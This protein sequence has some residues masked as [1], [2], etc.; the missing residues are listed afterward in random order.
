[1]EQLNPSPK[2]RVRRNQEPGV[3]EV[4][5]AAGVSIA[6]V[7]RV[8]NQPQVVSAKTRERVQAA[9]KEL[10]F[11]LNP[12]ASALRRGHGNVI[13]V[14]A[15]SLAQPWYT[16]LM[17]ALKVEIEARGFTVMQVD[18]QHDPEVLR[19][20]LL[21]N[22]QH[23]P[24]GMVLATGDL[25]AD[26]EIIDAIQAAHSTRPVVVIGQHVPDAEW[27]TVQFTDEEWAYQATREMLKHSASVA[28][29]GTLE[30]SYL[31]S[32]RL[33]GYLRAAREAD[34]DE[35]RW[36]WPIEA[37]GYAA[38]FEAVRRRI[39][40][41]VVP[42]AILAINDELALGASRALLTGELRIP[43][44]V[45]VMGFGNTDFLEYV[46]PTLS[47]VD[48]SAVDAARVAIDALWAQFDEHEF[49]RLTVL[50]RT[51]VHRESTRHDTRP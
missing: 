47:S 41:G 7:S 51:I 14:L 50:E 42:G 38:G 30:G 33:A 21:P 34:L 20:A 49:P 16:K 37:R 2:T 32:E 28:F 26:A 3:T 24:T 18:L 4:A 13:T 5:Q 45:A 22:S 8:L 48:G 36:V 43:E 11:H 40:Q 35:S 10:N 23:L 1:M 6:T 9:M 44:D 39:E 19:Q 31:A 27:P 12:A 29:L 46:T 25:L 17:R 15:A